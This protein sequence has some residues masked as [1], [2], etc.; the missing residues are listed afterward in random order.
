MY[1]LVSFRISSGLSLSCV[2]FTTLQHRIRVVESDYFFIYVNHLIL[3]ITEMIDLYIFVLYLIT[4]CVGATAL[5]MHPSIK[6]RTK[7]TCTQVRNQE[8]K[9]NRKHL[10]RLYYNN[11][12]DN[13]RENVND[14]N[15]VIQTSDVLA[16]MIMHRAFTVVNYQL[17]RERQL[18]K[19]QQNKLNE[20]T[21]REIERQEAIA[22][23]AK[24]N[25]EL[26]WNI[27]KSNDELE[28]G[29]S[30]VSDPCEEC[31][32]KGKVLCPFC[33]GNGFVDFGEQEKGT[34]GGS[35]VSRNGGRTH[36]E[37]PICDENGEQSC[38][39]C[40]GSGW[41]ARWNKPS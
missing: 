14:N 34:I 10:L 23:N 16:D 28:A 25:L 6:N 29:M 27:Q 40:S 30:N 33:Q 37:C 9:P 11:K 32:G 15:C 4:A 39:K 5:L 3:N 38:T 35:M 8:W 26:K 19:D 24:K 2:I 20:K 7:D 31:K 21:N 36:V 17:R 41:I 1:V 18:K 13:D 22:K 12:D